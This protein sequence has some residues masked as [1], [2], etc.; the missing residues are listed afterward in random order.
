MGRG[1]NEVRW[2]AG[3]REAS[4][5]VLALR[6]RGPRSTLQ[7]DEA[8]S[9]QERES[10]AGT[11]LKVAV[12][13]HAG[14][15][16]K[17]NEDAYAAVELDSS[18]TQ[19]GGASAKEMT[20][21]DRGVLLAVSDGM[22]G[23]AAGEVASA[24]VVESLTTML[25]A[26][27]DDEAAEAVLESAL[28]QANAGVFRAAK[29]GAK[30]GMGATLTAAW[31]LEDSVYL[32]Q[33]GDSRA[34]LLRSGRLHQLTRDQT[35][36]QMLLD[37]G[38]IQP[39][40][41]D[42]FAQKNWIVQA[43]GVGPEIQVALSCLELREGDRLLLCSDGLHGLVKDDTLAATLAEDDESAACDRL[44]D[45]ANKAGGTDNITAVVATVHGEGLPSAEPDAPLDETLEVISE[46]VARTDGAAPIASTPP[47]AM[48]GRGAYVLSI[49]V[50][51]IALLFTA[52][53]YWFVLA[54]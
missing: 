44:I 31:V 45:L 15:V 38:A 29:D 51:A 9:E 16:R 46:Y 28:H 5:V 23:H 54:K 4:E 37:S 21:G 26:A 53:G 6:D 7:A 43:V 17:R 40:Q 24:M 2:T 39:D 41:A 33:V 14:R 19:D 1:G 22:G 35:F 27:E 12:R 47:Q 36:L 42:N 25:R 18:T 8:G 11:A 32:A 13:T 10:M 48:G 52:A 30:E 34:Y 50:M 3:G 49:A 20:D